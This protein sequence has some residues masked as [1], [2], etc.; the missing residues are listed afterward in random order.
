MRYPKIGDTVTVVLE[1]TIVENGIVEEWGPEWIELM[2]PNTNTIS[3]IKEKYII[4]FK[5]LNSVADKPVN[6]KGVQAEQLNSLAAERVRAVGRVSI[7]GG[8]DQ[9]LKM[10][11]AHLDRIDSE[12]NKVQKH[13]EKTE[14]LKKYPVKYVSPLFIKIKQ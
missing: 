13:L 1:D 10:V 4:G 5:I 7:T 8:K 6:I 9:A 11:D 3:C 14:S 12:R 2:D